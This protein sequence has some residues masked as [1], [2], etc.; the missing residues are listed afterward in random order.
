MVMAETSAAGRPEAVPARLGVQPCGACE[1][2]RFSFCSAVR[3]EDLGRL[4]QAADR[5]TAKPGARIVGAEEPA[6]FVFNVGDGAVRVS[7]PLADGRRP[8]VGFL[9]RGDFLGFGAGE[10]YG[11]Q[12]DALTPVTVC[13]FERGAFRALMDAFPPMERRLLCMASD[14]IRE[15]QE[16]MALL[17]RKTAPERL[18]T[19]LLKLSARQ[20]RLGGAED[21]AVLPMSRSDVA[22]YLGLTAETVSRVLTS[23]KVAGLIRLERASRIRLLRPAALADLAAGGS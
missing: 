20:A 9:L 13:R 3:D 8:V 10:T 19:F 23:F 22:D 21:L 7:R 1:A 2:R 15:G 14:E 18:A 5:Y 6:N 11:F 12:A 16:Q 17:G 4:A